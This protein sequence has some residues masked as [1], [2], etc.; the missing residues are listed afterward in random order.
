MSTTRWT[1]TATDD[2]NTAVDLLID[3][4]ANDER[5]STLTWD[6]W[7]LSKAYD[8][9]QTMILNGRNIKYNFI[10]YSYDQISSGT[11]PVEDRT[12][13][14]SGFIIAYH[15]GISI[16]YIIDRNSNA[17][18]MLRKLLSYTGKNEVEKNTYDFS[19]DF[20]VWLISKVFNSDNIIESDNDNLCNLQLESIKGF[21]G[22]TEDSQ[23]KVSADGESVINIISTL[24][25]LLE[26]SR[27][28]QIKLDLSYADHENIS[29]LLNKGVVAVDSK[30]YQGSFES[31]DETTRIAKLYLLIY[32]ELLPILE[33]AYQSDIINDMWGQQ[34]YINF[35]NN[36][37]TKLT[38]KIQKK[39]SSINEP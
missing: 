17:Q 25:F 1:D 36:V 31:E 3:T 6:N 15:N 16:N 12:V 39:I 20:F 8:K 9:T 30:S 13:K 33:Q 22:N 27:L 4:V 24:S 26:S 5:V 21:R 35:M 2:L 37:A 11:R 10:N 29:L 34:E 18:K 19:T 7:Q 28:N 23:T 14:K 38:D 32:L